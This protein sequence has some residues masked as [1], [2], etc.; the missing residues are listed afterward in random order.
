MRIFNGIFADSKKDAEEEVK[1]EISCVQNSAEEVYQG[2]KVPSK[3]GKR[4]RKRKSYG[5]DFE[6]DESEEALDVTDDKDKDGITTFLPRHFMPLN[7][8]S[9]IH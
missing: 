1:R 4:N 8:D 5:K 2:E 6:S 9:N 3:L 7:Y